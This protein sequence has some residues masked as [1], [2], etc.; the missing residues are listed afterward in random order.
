MINRLFESLQ[1]FSKA[2]S[3]RIVDPNTDVFAGSG[4]RSW[5]SQEPDPQFQKIGSL[6]VFWEVYLNP[7]N[8]TSNI[9]KIFLGCIQIK[10]DP[11]ILSKSGSA[12][13]KS[14]NTD[15]EFFPAWIRT[16]YFWIGSISGHLHPD[17]TAGIK[18]LPL[19]LWRFLI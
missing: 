1:S 3:Y 18:S 14:R 10:S 12:L 13:W 19:L 16:S 17:P 11:G 4:P 9:L 5:K 7:S 6:S 15:P 8:N 2:Q